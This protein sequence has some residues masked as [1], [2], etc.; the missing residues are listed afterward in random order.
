MLELLAREP[1]TGYDISRRMQAPIGYM[2]TASHSS[3]YGELASLEHD[4]LIVSRVVDGPGPRDTKR[5]R[6]T[7]AGRRHLEQWVDSPVSHYPVRDELM[8]RVRS[9]WLISPERCRAFLNEVLLER[10]RRLAVYEDEE[11]DFGRQGLAVHDPSGWAF[12]AYATV[13]AGIRTERA[14]IDWCRWLLDELYVPA[15]HTA[16]P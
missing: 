10:E 6:I 2:W 16:R 4:R 12:G 3:V 5:Y 8:L 15:P 7:P 9:F 11:R 14:M 1:M 13:Q